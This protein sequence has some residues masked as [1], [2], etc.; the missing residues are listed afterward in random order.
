MDETEK[1]D[2]SEKMDESRTGNK[3]EESE[4]EKKC[5]K[6]EKEGKVDHTKSWLIIIFSLLCIF[7]NN[8][9]VSTI[10]M[11]SLFRFTRITV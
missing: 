4:R 2:K 10:R 8:I 5:D 7:L 9:I 3:I 6:T 1:T 11:R